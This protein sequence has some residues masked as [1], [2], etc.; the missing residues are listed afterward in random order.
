MNDMLPSS[1]H[2]A[3]PVKRLIGPRPD[4]RPDLSKRI[5]TG[6]LEPYSRPDT[7]PSNITFVRCHS[8]PV[9]GTAACDSSAAWTCRHSNPR[10]ND[11]ANENSM[12]RVAKLTRFPPF[13]GID[14]RQ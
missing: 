11:S 14:S 3:V 6:E 1:D 9:S 10:A 12:F 2:L 8:V 13:Y 7:A 5:V 4:T